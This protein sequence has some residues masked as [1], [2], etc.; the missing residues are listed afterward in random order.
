MPPEI[1][2]DCLLII[3]LW[4]RTILTDH[5][6]L[7]VEEQLEKSIVW[8]PGALIWPMSIITLSTAFD[9]FAAGPVTCPA[10]RD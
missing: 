2:R 7:R 1:A 4:S 9:E 8:K 3:N 5:A 6:T 10:D